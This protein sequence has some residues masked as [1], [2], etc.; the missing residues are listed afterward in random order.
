MKSKLYGIYLPINET[1]RE[2]LEINRQGGK[3]NAVACRATSNR[4]IFEMNHCSGKKWGIIF[5]QIPISLI[6]TGLRL[7]GISCNSQ[8]NV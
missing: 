7:Q 8:R 5:Y 6:L 2:T 3:T 4:G 1:Y